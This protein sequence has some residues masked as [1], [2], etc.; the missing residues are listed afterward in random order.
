MAIYNAWCG[1]VPLFIILGNRL[2]LDVRRPGPEWV[3]TGRDGAAMVRDYTKWDDN[4]TSLQHVA[5]SAVRA[6]KNAMTV[7]REP[8]L[9]VAD[10]GLQEAGIKDEKALHI[11][12]TILPTFPAGDAGAVAETARTLVAAEFPVI[13]ADRAARTPHGPKL[14][15]ARAEL[16]QAAVIDPG[17][18]RNFP[19]TDP[20]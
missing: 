13:I 11:P 14:L 19:S 6:Y 3:H 20:A 18:R 5:E 1:R 12:K 10:L 9:L 2:D 4:P 7:P 17:L 15:L 16:L 8:V